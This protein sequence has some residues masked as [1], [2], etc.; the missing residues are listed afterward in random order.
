MVDDKIVKAVKDIRKSWKASDDKRDAGLPH[1]IPNVRRIDNVQYGSDRNWNLLDIYLPENV[2]GKLPVIINIHGGDWIYGTKS[3][4]QYYGLGLAKRGFAFVN[5]SFKLGPDVQFPGEL[6][7]I[8]QYIHWVDENA[9][10]YN[11]DR[12]NVFLVADSSGGNLAEEYVTCLTNPKYRDKFGYDLTNLKFRAVALNSPVTFVLECGILAVGPLAEPASAYFTPEVMA[13]S[14]TKDLMQV[15]NYIT[16]DFLPTFLTTANQDPLHDCA[17]RLDGFLKA[18][19]VEEVYKSFGD[20]KHPEPHVFIINQKDS[21]A[22]KANDE[23]I[24]FFKKHMK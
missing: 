12:N 11:F 24:E 4:Y 15:E 22:N 23:E 9:D 3:T 17:A 14:E 2:S 10:K 6:D 1:D 18:K 19:G 5:P 20:D 16:K 7:Q 13:K 21:L 8:N